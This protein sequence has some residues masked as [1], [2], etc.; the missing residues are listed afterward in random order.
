MII[1]RKIFFFCLILSIAQWAQAQT[2]PTAVPKTNRIAPNDLA[3]LQTQEAKLK[4]IFNFNYFTTKIYDTLRNLD[5]TQRKNE[6]LM[7]S[8]AK[9]LVRR[10]YIRRA[11]ANDTFVRHFVKTLKTP[12]SFH[13]P[14]DSLVARGMSIVKS[15]DEKFR[16]ITWSLPEHDETGAYTYLYFGAIQ[17][18]TSILRL[19]P[20]QDKSGQMASPDQKNGDNSEW[21]G[22]LYYG[23]TQNTH[24]DTTYY[25]V[26]G[27]DGNNERSTK[28]IADVLYFDADGKP[29]FGAPIFQVIKNNKLLFRS[30]FIMEFKEGATVTLNWDAE[31]NKII[32]DNLSSEDGESTKKTNTAG[33]TSAQNAG[34]GNEFTLIPEGIYSGLEFREGKWYYIQTVM[35][36]FL[37]SVPIPAPVLNKDSGKMPLKKGAKDKTKSKG[38]SKNK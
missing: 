10:D 14:F 37:K 28:K 8:L 32:F 31:Q 2:Q 33:V 1:M 15:P 7:E 21:F 3:S 20:L 17:M 9:K 26:F 19:F 27:W 23:I 13:Y 30:R 34:A 12:N 36:E 22:A 16:I 4:D 24:N 18:D 6:K 29:K 25:T 35:R 5:T 38:K 11:Q